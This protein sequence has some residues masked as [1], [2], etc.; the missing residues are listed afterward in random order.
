M[1]KIL[2]C[3]CGVKM[4]RIAPVLL[5]V[6]VGVTF[7][8]HG[9]QKISNGVPGFSGFLDGLGVPAAGFFAYLVTYLEFLGGIALI[10]GL[11]T[12]WF[13]KLLAVDMIFAT[14][15]VHIKN[16]FFISNGGY[17]FVLLLFAACFVIMATG[18]GPWSLDE[19]LFR[20]RPEARTPPVQPD[21]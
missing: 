4:I 8:L 17:E 21:Q 7:V 6:V 5:R 18:A 2:D 1:K 15:L 11:L 14:F 12:H 19:I 13:A 16:G 3:R 20:K 10:L 9:Y